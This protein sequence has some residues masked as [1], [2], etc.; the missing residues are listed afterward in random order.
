MSKMRFVLCS[1]FLSGVALIGMQGCSSETEDAAEDE[2]IFTNE[3]PVDDEDLSSDSEELR[4]SCS[5]CV[6]YA[7]ARQPGLPNGLY[8][9]G[10]KARI[11]NSQVARPGC[12]AIIRTGHKWGHVAYVTST[13]GAIHIA[14][15]NWPSGRCGRRVGTARSLNISGYWCPS[16][17]GSRGNECF[18]GGT[19]CGGDKVS[20]DKNTLY[21]CNRSGSGTS[22]VKRCANGCRVNPGQ[23]DTCK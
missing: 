7:K 11:I 22:V 2:E 16:S 19:Y 3:G 4:A 15:G 5:N 10:D 6:Y 13:R 8:T 17:G 21:R 18:P 12:V 1:V 9:Y 20:G 23:N 14:E